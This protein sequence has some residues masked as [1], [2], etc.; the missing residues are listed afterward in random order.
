MTKKALLVLLVSLS[1]SGYAA[2]NGNGSWDPTPSELLLDQ[3]EGTDVFAIP[4]DQSDVEDNYEIREM[5]EDQREYFRQHP[6]AY[7]KWLE[8]RAKYR[9]QP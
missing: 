2:Q 3:V 7:K 1:A 4:L 5:R 8:S 6:E 9:R